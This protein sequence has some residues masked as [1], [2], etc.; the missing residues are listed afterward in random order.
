MRWKR[1]LFFDFGASNDNCRARRR[2]HFQRLFITKLSG[3]HEARHV[4]HKFWDSFWKST[5]K[6]WNWASLNGPQVFKSWWDMSCHEAHHEE[7]IKTHHAQWG[8]THSKDPINK[9]TH[10]FF[11]FFSV[12]W[13]EERWAPENYEEQRVRTTQMKRKTFLS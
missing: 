12:H 10:K 11:T 7:P 2:N 13:P 4:L 6:T 1:L 5:S 8:Q 9:N 3:F